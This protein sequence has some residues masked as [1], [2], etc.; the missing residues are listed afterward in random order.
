MAAFWAEPAGLASLTHIVGCAGAVHVDQ[1]DERFVLASLVQRI[2]AVHEAHRVKTWRE[3]DAAAL[4]FKLVGE[5]G[6]D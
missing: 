3:V 2:F 1:C 4:E 5:E 6:P